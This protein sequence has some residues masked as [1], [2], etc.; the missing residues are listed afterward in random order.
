MK[1]TRIFSIPAFFFSTL[2]VAGIGL[3]LWL[4]GGQA[5]SPGYLSAQN[6]PGVQ[7]GGYG[8]HADF[9]QRC[10]LCHDPLRTTQDTL[11]LVC[12][13]EIAD[14]IAQTNGTH[15][16][17]QPPCYQCHSD[18]QG[19]DFNLLMP[20]LANFDHGKAGFSLIRHQLGYDTLPMECSACH[21][22]NNSFALD[23][24]LCLSCHAEHDPAF[25][26][27]HVQTFG[28]D[29]LG[30]H[31]GSDRL[32]GFDHTQ[33]HFPLTGN[34]AEAAC[35][36]CH[37]LESG[38]GKLSFA[39]FQATP[40]AC[41]NCHTEPAM[42]QGLFS[43]DCS[44]CHSSLGWQPAQWQG[45]VFDH[46]ADS[47]FSL[48][49]HSRDRAGE[50]LTCTACHGEDLA[51]LAIDEPNPDPSV[52]ANCISCHSTGDTGAAFMQ[53]HQEQYGTACLDCH[54][55]VD[56]MSGFDHASIFPLEGAHERLECGKCHVDRQFTG[57]PREC[58]ACHTEPE[59]HAGFFGDQCQDCHTTQAWTPAQLRNHSFPLNHGDQ[60]LVACQ[61]CH[62]NRYTEYTCYGCHE[63]DPNR[64][65]QEHL[66]ENV[67]LAELQNCVRCHPN[68][69]EAE[70]DD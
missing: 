30:C 63:H 47:G 67:N 60:G 53:R 28:E 27:R 21:D 11:C 13:T 15:S 66:E 58:A 31:D 3:G 23:Q 24:Q 33:T 20:G 46:L 8:S 39:S 64:I 42:H 32:A 49:R 69:Q 12:H 5:F 57:T 10:S 70:G 29:C 14:Q 1:R 43:Q 34:H 48:A 62:P 36:E 16:Q 51:G 9:E 6:R 25:M 61:T 17:V 65:E 56:R 52:L 41:I 44:E 18:H 2:L 59:I 35:E 45:Q 7:I 68:G 26:T 50:A 54:D 37:T 40:S 55:G 22:V 4:R 38:T 19:R